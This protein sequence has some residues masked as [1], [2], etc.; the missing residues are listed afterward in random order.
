VRRGVITHRD[1]QGESNWLLHRMYRMVTKS[2]LGLQGTQM[3]DLYTGE[4]AVSRTGLC[5][6][7]WQGKGLYSKG[8]SH[9][10]SI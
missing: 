7:T 2:E 4:A 5:V 1:D 9:E 8:V 6:S 3:A 10:W